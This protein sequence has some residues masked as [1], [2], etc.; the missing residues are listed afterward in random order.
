M[1]PLR[2]ILM[3]CGMALISACSAQP[4]SAQI[5]LRSVYQSPYCG[6]E[7]PGLRWLEP[8]EFA[9]LVRGAGAGQH[10][11]SEPAPVPQI[12]T[13]ERVLQVSLGQKGS[14]G[15]A[16]VLSDNTAQVTQG[17]LMLPLTIE[18]PSDGSMQTMQLTYPCLVIAL[19]H[20]G[21]SRVRG[22]NIG[23]IPAEQKK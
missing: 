23:E 6:T 18:Q 14:G 15:H 11:G 2:S 13:D 8:E 12:D 22:G 5:S 21:Y 1:T 4:K 17:V 16:V 3:F 10:L 19:P 9:A 20:H 7:E